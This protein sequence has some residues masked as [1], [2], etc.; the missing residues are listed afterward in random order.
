MGTVK[1]QEGDLPP[2]L[3]IE[4]LPKRQ[5][6]ENLKIGL[7]RWLQRVESH[8]NVKPIIYSGDSY[9]TDFLEQEFK[10]YPFWIA[11][12]TQ[13]IEDIDNDWR[14]WQ[15]TEKATVSGVKGN[16]DLNVFNGSAKELNYLTI[17]N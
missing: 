7:K 11:N 14:F 9:Y 12:Y 13:E 6:L 5:S 1:L 3:D 16:V 15:F 2:V 4:K 10:E 8:Y 17:G